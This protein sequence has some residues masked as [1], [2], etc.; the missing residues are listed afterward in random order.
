MIR[1]CHPSSNVAKN[2]SRS[3]GIAETAESLFALPSLESN[4]EYNSM[5]FRSSAYIEDMEA[6]NSPTSGIL[7]GRITESEA[8]ESLSANTDVPW[9]EATDE[10]GYYADGQD[11]ESSP[12][13]RDV[14][15]QI[16]EGLIALDLACG[17]KSQTSTRNRTWMHA[18]P[19]NSDRSSLLTND[20]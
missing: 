10:Y 13:P 17:C 19:V 1:P 6:G 12:S 14:L 4:D 9:E 3:G 15:P 5:D 2:H 11:I 20:L 18:R 8:G 7:S 16:M